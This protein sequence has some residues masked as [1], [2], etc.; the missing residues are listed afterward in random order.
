MVAVLTLS[1][2][3]LV[4]QLLNANDLVGDDANDPKSRSAVRI[5]PISQ[6]KCVDR[7]GRLGA[8]GLGGSFG[9]PERAD[10][11][12]C[13]LTNLRPDSV[14]SRHCGAVRRLHQRF[15]L[16]SSSERVDAEQ[17]LSRVPFEQCA[18]DVE[19]CGARGEFI[20]SPTYEGQ[21]LDPIADPFIDVSRLARAG[22]P[23]L[24]HVPQGRAFALPS[25]P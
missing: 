12:K 17:H 2:S 21:A 8:P 15:D 10:V 6:M 13:T 7:G 20:S 3:S 4:F 24:S 11:E 23:S 19:H 1:L 5:S 16:A 18:V 22:V 14:G 25:H 9:G